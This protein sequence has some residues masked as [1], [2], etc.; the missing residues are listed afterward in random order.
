MNEKTPDEDLPK[1]FAR[2]H[3]TTKI[4]NYQAYDGNWRQRVIMSKVYF[5]EERKG[6]FLEHFAETGR[7]QHS[8][9]MAG[10]TAVTVREHMKRDTEF[11]EAVEVSRETYADKV[12]ERNSDIYFNP[13]KKIN[14]DRNGKVISEEDLVFPLLNAMELKAHCAEYRDRQ[15]VTHNHTGGV[16]LIP[17]GV[18]S[19]DDWEKRFGKQDSSPSLEGS[20][21][22]LDI[23]PTVVDE[24]PSPDG[25]S[26]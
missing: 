24:T 9:Q 13:P 17:G 16:M 2:R 10:V 7:M 15:E 4:V 18:D 19:A 8:A 23:T 22:I 11:A 26:D 5:N 1:G 14:Y 25:K 12:R 20:T 21:D 3:G 6:I